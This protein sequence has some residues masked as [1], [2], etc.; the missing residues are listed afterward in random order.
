MFGQMAA[1]AAGIL[2]ARKHPGVRKPHQQFP[3]SWLRDGNA[4]RIHG[5]PRS[6][7]SGTAFCFTSDTHI[8]GR[9]SAGTFLSPLSWIAIALP[10]AFSTTRAFSLRAADPWVEIAGISLIFLCV[11]FTSSFARHTG[12]LG[13]AQFTRLRFR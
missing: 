8:S 9:E 10:W 1:W 4:E 7:R 13:T 2:L 3:Y 11:I 5:A 6:T 12:L